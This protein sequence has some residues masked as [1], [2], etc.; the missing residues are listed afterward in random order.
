M[1][2][3]WTERKFNVNASGMWRNMV[4]IHCHL[5]PGVDDGVAKLDDTLSLLCYMENEVGVNKVCMTPHTMSDYNCGPTD[6]L[7]DKFKKIQSVYAGGITLSLSS[8]YMIDMAFYER[9]RN[10]DLLSLG[11]YEN[12]NLLLVETPLTMPL[13]HLDKILEDIFSAGYVPVIAHPE[14][15]LYMDCQKYRILRE[16]GCLFQMNIPSLYGCYG[17]E[18][19]KRAEA[20][21]DKEMYCFAGFDIHSY[22]NYSKV[23]EGLKLKRKRL[24]RL[25]ELLNNNKFIY[26]TGG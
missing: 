5:L 23:V 6:I 21:L 9:L 15:Y 11:E 19:K 14:R 1:V 10:G 16:S 4:E 3:F 26:V 25:G 24:E 20:L 2:A 8:E 7:I 13:S 17:R 22:E 12:Y 18:V